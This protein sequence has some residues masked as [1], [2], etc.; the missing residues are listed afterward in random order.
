MKSINVFIID[1]EQPARERLSRFCERHPDLDICGTA[2][3]ALEALENIPKIQ[4]DLLLLDIQMP[5][6]TG[7][8][9]LAA[10]E[11]PPP[12]IFTTAY[13]QYALKAFE[14][15][16]FDY[17]L[18]PFSFERF[19]D[20]I[21]R[22]LTDGHKT[23][24]MAEENFPRLQRLVCKV[25]GGYKIIPIQEI[26]VFEA[27][28][29]Y[30]RAHHNSNE[31]DLLDTSLTKL[32]KR[33]EGVFIRTHRSFLSRLDAIKSIRSTEGSSYRIHVADLDI[34]LSRSRLSIVKK[35]LGQFEDNDND[36]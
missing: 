20:A 3:N 24:S 23:N 6:L 35:A 5:E 36:E 25:S 30:V 16:A 1:D 9:L 31:N 14:V 27:R 22:F 13:D 19:E 32:E 15:S 29:D 12:V 11:N 8:D 7:F 28:G 33:L 26:V 2:A 18:K 10:L 4:P 34:P 17:L 21:N